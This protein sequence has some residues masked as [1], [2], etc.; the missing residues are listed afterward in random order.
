MSAQSHAYPVY[1]LDVVG[2][3]NANNLISASTDGRVCS[4]AH[5]MLSE[6][7]VCAGFRYI[8][9]HAGLLVHIWPV[10]SLTMPL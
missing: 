1:C 9:A 3:Q 8:Y 7:L 4:W 6:P 2:T 5:D 10:T